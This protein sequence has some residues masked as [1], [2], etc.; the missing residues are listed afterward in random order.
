MTLDDLIGLTLFLK[1]LKKDKVL[2][3][4][5]ITEKHDFKILRPYVTFNL[6]GHTFL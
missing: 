1:L 5:D 2:N 6:R 3:K 4:R